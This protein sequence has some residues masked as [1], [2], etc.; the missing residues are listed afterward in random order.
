V[1]HRPWATQIGV[2]SFSQ[3]RVARACQ[4]ESRVEDACPVDQTALAEGGHADNPDTWSA[5]RVKRA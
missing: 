5:L 4:Q 1:E 3:P 2:T